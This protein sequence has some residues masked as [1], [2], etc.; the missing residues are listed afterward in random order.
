MV[1][2]DHIETARWVGIQSGIIEKEDA[3]KDGVVMTGDEF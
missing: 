1:T 2:G 3:Y